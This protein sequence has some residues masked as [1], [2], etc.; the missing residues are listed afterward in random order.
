MDDDEWYKPNR[1]PAPPRQPQPG[2]RL[3]EF[4]RDRDHTQWLCEL[5]DPGEVHGVEAQ[6]FRNVEFD[7]SRRFDR[8][9]DPTRAPR[10]LAIAWAEEWR[11]GLEGGGE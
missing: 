8:R 11:K 7:S 3:F 1:P 5:R 4:Y 9:M 10:E 2:E 6:F